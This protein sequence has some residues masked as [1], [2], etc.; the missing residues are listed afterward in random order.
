MTKN[1]YPSD[2]PLAIDV[3]NLRFSYD[4]AEILRLDKLQVGVGESMAIVGPSGCGKTTLLHLLAGLVQ[5]TAGQVKIFG[6]DLSRLR[7]SQ[8]DRFRG[9]HIGLIFQ[10]FHLLPALTVLQNITLARYLARAT[11][12]G[13]LLAELFERLN[14]NG[15]EHHKPSMLSHGQAQRVAI[16]RALVHQPRLLMADEPT[17]AL[18]DGRA[19]AVITL[20][21]ETAAA[22][23]SALLVVTHDQRIRGRLGSELELAKS[24]PAQSTVQTA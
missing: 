11:A 23:G 20:L 3:A 17:S 13:A 8:L 22:V 19:A 7:N 5:P 15:L 14:L 12:N 24:E 4:S 2:K 18:D 1:T 21:E 16:A 10:R 6:Q 9:Q